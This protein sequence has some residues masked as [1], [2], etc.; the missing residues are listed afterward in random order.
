MSFL[1]T[2]LALAALGGAT[3]YYIRRFRKK[4]TTV[5]KLMLVAMRRREVGMKRSLELSREEHGTTNA[6]LEK[7]WRIL[8]ER[9]IGLGAH[10]LQGFMSDAAGLQAPGDQDW[11]LFFLYELQD[12]AMFQKCIQAFEGEGSNLLRSHLEVRLIPGEKMVH[13]SNK[14]KRLL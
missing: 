8:H 4:T 9:W 2:L 6:H 12:Y 10:Y 1:V 13:I 7:Q 5:T 11:R 3:Y 14:L